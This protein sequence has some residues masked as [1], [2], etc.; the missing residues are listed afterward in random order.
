MF[1]LA[2][3][4]G[5]LLCQDWSAGPS[6]ATF[7]EPICGS[8]FLNSLLPNGHWEELVRFCDIGSWLR[9]TDFS[10]AAVVVAASGLL[11][12]PTPLPPCETVPPRPRL[13]LSDHPSQCASKPAHYP[14]G[15]GR[16]LEIP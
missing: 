9:F 14:P 8:G 4:C 16:L 12:S 1:L 5:S 11:L 13:A 2:D 6:L 15:T 3:S 7:G 10:F